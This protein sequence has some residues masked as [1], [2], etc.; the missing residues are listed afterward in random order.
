[1]NHALTDSTAKDS[2]TDQTDWIFCHPGHTVTLVPFL[3]RVPRSTCS[4]LPT[5]NLGWIAR[6]N[7]DSM[8]A[9][10]VP[11]CEHD[12]LF[13]NTPRSFRY[14]CTR[15]FINLRFEININE[16]DTNS[17]WDLSWWTGAFHCVCMHVNESN[18]SLDPSWIS[19]PTTSA[20]SNF[21]T[22]APITISN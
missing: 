4:R 21:L 14:N 8:N 3:T 10:L 2:R 5:D 16:Y 1:M 15:G 7:T 6:I 19:F 20:S 9:K 13:A 11:P 22:L 12:G 18:P 17:W